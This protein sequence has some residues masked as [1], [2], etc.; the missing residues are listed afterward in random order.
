MSLA[1]P[2]RVVVDGFVD[3]V[4]L[5]TLAACTCTTTIW[6]D[7]QVFHFIKIQYE[8]QA[9]SVSGPAS[10]YNE[11]DMELKMLK[12]YA[13]AV[14]HVGAWDSEWRLGNDARMSRSP[15]FDL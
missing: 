14:L 8:Y 4:T 1:R 7:A 6:L 11:W 2:S 12:R 3:S 15:S 10:D 13:S 5:V 9:I